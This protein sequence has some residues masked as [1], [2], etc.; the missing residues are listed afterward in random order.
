M[1]CVGEERGGEGMYGG[2]CTEYTSVITCE[3]GSGVHP[4]KYTVVE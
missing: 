3:S 2:K 1:Q 4:V